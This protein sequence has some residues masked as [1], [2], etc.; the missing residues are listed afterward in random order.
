MQ[1][2]DNLGEITEKEIFEIPESLKR[3]LEQ[4]NLVIK[5]AKEIVSRKT[6]HIYL[7]GAGSSYH[8]GYAI[9]YMFNRISQTPAS[10]EFSMEFQYLIKPILY[11]NDC[12]IALSQ[13]G[14]TIDTI[15]AVEIG[16]K[17]GCLTI[18]IT[19]SDNST[20][21]KICDFSVLLKCGEETSV[22]ATKTYV[23]Q[24][25]VLAM[26]SLE[27][28]IIRKSISEVE[29]ND[30]YNELNSI[31]KNV[32][33][34]LPEIHKN[35]KS[36]SNYFKFLNNCFI[37]G[38]GPDYATAMEAA[39]K[40]KEGARIFAQAYSTAEF[41]HG[42]ITLA[43]SSTCIIAII[44]HEE[45]LRKQNLID[46]LKRLKSRKATILG[47]YETVEGSE[48]PSPIDFGIQ[49]PNTIIDLQPLII[50]LGV[51]LLTLEIS[52]IKGINCDTPKYLTKISG[53]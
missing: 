25:A 22:L 49:V 13:S 10:A 45:D 17:K 44:P 43:D 11:E 31:C 28:G 27:I 47:I 39:L 2:P 12:L 34:I 50:I 36:I 51:Q 40:L 7:V 23:S 52:R 15:E 29:Y 16:K 30:I 20:L 1:N 38:T 46:L 14:E 26:F 18:G 33:K 8:A 3:S 41:P 48:I 37:L 6:N 42:P 4:K 24:L 53:I 5:L 21:K 35:I 19:N 32:K 9:S